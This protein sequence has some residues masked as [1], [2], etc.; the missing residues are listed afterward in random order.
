MRA[1][2]FGYC[3][4]PPCHQPLRPPQGQKWSWIRKRMKK[5]ILKG[6]QRRGNIR[7]PQ[8]IEIFLMNPC[9]ATF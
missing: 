4:F 9:A 7:T 5:K 6:L 3:H 8:C 1:K 2:E